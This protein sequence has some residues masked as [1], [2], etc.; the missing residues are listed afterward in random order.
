MHTPS[1]ALQPQTGPYTHIPGVAAMALV[2]QPAHPHTSCSSRRAVPW[3]VCGGLRP[4]ADAPGACNAAP[5]RQHIQNTHIMVCVPGP[6]GHTHN[7][8]TSMDTCKPIAEL[9][10]LAE[11]PLE[12]LT[13]L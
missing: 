12:T 6:P 9:S 3:Q 10:R 13:Q 11:G 8:I 1:S 2:P 5:L 4:T 7:S